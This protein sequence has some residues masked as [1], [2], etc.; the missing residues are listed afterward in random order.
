MAILR[1]ARVK[2]VRFAGGGLEV[3]LRDGRKISVPLTWFSKLSSANA[4]DRSI[5]E[6]S[7]AGYGIHWPLINEDLSV[8]GLLRAQSAS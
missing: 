6:V 5:W 1:D 3:L 2:D 4:S 7:A 8:E